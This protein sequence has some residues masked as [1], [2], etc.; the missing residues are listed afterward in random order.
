M[1]LFAGAEGLTYQDAL[2]AVGWFID[3]EGFQNCRLI[4]HEDGLVLQ[5]ARAGDEPHG[6]QTFLF[7]RD[8]LLELVREAV[9]SRSGPPGTAG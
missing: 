4:E 7:T 2:R 1:P 9:A 5:V 6:Y 3:R 8:E